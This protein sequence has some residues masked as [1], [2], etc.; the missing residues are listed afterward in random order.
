V[1]TP[2]FSSPLTVMQIHPLNKTIHP[3]TG[4]PWNKATPETRPCILKWGHTWNNA[5]H[6]RYEVTPEGRQATRGLLAPLLY[7]QTLVH[8]A[9]SLT[10]LQTL[11]HPAWSLTMAVESLKIFFSSKKNH[12]PQILRSTVHLPSLHSVNT[13]KQKLRISN[14]FPSAR[15]Y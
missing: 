9:W 3:K 8:P 4:H 12:P 6:P 15:I 5:G 1:A 10:Y 14:L 13:L 2:A 7:L 11:V